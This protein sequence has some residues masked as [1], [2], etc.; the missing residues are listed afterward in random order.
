MSLTWKDTVS[1]PPSTSD[2]GDINNYLK[3][4]VFTE[5]PIDR[6]YSGRDKILNS[7]PKDFA[8]N[9]TE[10]TNL[11]L[12]G[13]VSLVEEYIR[14]LLTGIIKLCPTTRKNGASK[15]VTL[16]TVYIGYNEV[17]KGIFENTSYS[18][19]AAIKKD[20]KNLIN[21]DISSSSQIDAPLNEF[22][23][24]CEL[25]HAVVHSSGNIAGKNA[26]KLE[27]GR[28]K[29][30]TQVKI[31]YN[32]LQTTALI[33]T[34]LV[35]A[36]NIELFKIISERWLRDWPR[37]QAYQFKNLN[38]VFKEIWELFYSTKDAERGEITYPITYLKVRN[39][40][41]KTAF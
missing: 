13:L 19:V 40:L 28:S 36:L 15:P 35:R 2:I 12:V 3:A 17:E 24:I 16:G 14:N 41:S 33:C 30:K 23:K 4:D 18:D 6:F 26:V 8:D 38:P 21:L 20:L 25:R 9:N 29:N 34:S 11:A 10:I 7:L 32:G 22:Q 37:S 5:C 27:L 31:D 39:L 1:A